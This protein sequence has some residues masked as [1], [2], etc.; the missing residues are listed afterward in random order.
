MPF[1]LKMTRRAPRSTLF[2][3]TTLFRSGSYTVSGSTAISG[4]TANFNG[5][6]TSAGGA[7]SG[8]NLSRREEYTSGLQSHWARVCRIVRETTVIAGGGSLVLSGRNNKQ[9]GQRTIN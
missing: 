7:L 6:A 9:L 8:G 3:Y 5:N 4:G 1:F 2:P